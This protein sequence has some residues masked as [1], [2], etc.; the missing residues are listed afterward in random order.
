MNSILLA[1]CCNKIPVSLEDLLWKSSLLTDNI[2]PHD[3]M[4]NYCSSRGDR[5]SFEVVG[6]ISSAQQT[7][8]SG[9]LNINTSKY[10]YMNA[11]S[12]PNFSSFS[13]EIVKDK[14]KNGSFDDFISDLM[15]KLNKL[16]SII[17][18]KT[19][20]DGGGLWSETTQIQLFIAYLFEKWYPYGSSHLN[21]APA[22]K[23]SLS[24]NFEESEDRWG[25][26]A[27]LHCF[28][29][30]NVNE[31]I[32]K[33]KATFEVKFPFDT[34]SFY[35]SKAI[36]PK[37]QLLGQSVDLSR[38]KP[39]ENLYTLSYL[40]DIFAISVLYHIEGIAYLSERVAEPKPFCL[41]LL[42]M[43]CELTIEEWNRLIPN[44]LNEVD[45]IDDNELSFSK[46]KIKPK[47]I[48]LVVRNIASSLLSLMFLKFIMVL[49]IWMKRSI[50]TEE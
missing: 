34:K 23:D 46:K 40:T 18:Y 37:Q 43:C 44:E 21:I 14:F 32:N 42:L 20:I 36:Q 16:R 22:N 50:I 4:E 39:S 12:R 41:R 47:V 13:F 35:H 31:D 5:N 3:V 19:C 2:I 33:S 17:Y 6:E 28:K 30:L 24:I 1:L 38:N 10:A 49:L 11:E 26:K 15:I 27:D 48:I 25:G 29:S 45:L 7:T 8:P 9:K